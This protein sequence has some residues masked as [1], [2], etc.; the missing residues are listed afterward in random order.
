MTPFLPSPTILVFCSEGRHQF[1]AEAAAHVLLSAKNTHTWN[2]KKTNKY[3]K[4]LLLSSSLR[5]ED[6]NYSL[7][8]F[9]RKS[10]KETNRDN[11]RFLDH[12]P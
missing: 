8:F 5:L 9:C 6:N 3:T 4:E 11:L 12:V 7:S 2:V 10:N 1:T